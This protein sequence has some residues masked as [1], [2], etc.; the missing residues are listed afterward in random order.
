MKRNM[1]LVVLIEGHTNEAGPG[2][3]STVEFHQ[4]LSENRAKTIYNYLIEKGIDNNRLSTRGYGCS[5]MLYPNGTL[6]SELKLNRR[7]ELKVLDY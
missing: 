6:E 1:T 3:K 2:P 7:V 4:E 5:K